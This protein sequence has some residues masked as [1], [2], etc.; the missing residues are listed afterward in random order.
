[1][2]ISKAQIKKL[3]DPK[4]WKRGINYYEQGNVLSLLEDKET[5]IAKVAGTRNYKVRL[6]FKNSQLK[7]LCNCPMGDMGVFC[8]HCVAVGL[9]YM[10]G[11]NSDKNVS[12]TNKIKTS[13]PAITL[14]NVREYLSRKQT[15]EL[16]EIIT[17]QLIENDSL[18]ERLMMEVAY[19]S[20]KEP[21]VSA[22]KKT[23][24][25]VTKTRGFV[26]YHR[27]YD[28]IKK[29]DN[30]LDLVE[31]LL[32]TG[33]AKE[34]IELSEHALKHVEKA[35]GEMDDSDGYIGGILERLQILHHD[36]C[37]KNKPDPKE[38]ARRLFE[39]ELTTAWDTFYH[40]VETYTDVLGEEGLAVYR[41]LAEAE[42]AKLPPLKP[43]QISL[44]YRSNRYRLTSIME[45]LTKIS[46]DVEQLVA[47]KS[48]DLSSAYQFLQIAGIYKESGNSDKALEWAEKGVK[49][50]SDNP[51][52][53]LNEFLA[54]EYHNR[55]LHNQAMEL[56]WQ[57]FTRWPDLAFYQHLKK[58]ADRCNQWSKWRLK[59][60]EYV[61]ELINETKKQAEDKQYYG[62]STRHSNNSILI[63]IFLWENDIEAAWKEAKQGG[64]HDYLWLRLAEL[65]EKNYPADAIGVYKEQIGPLVGQTKNEA[66]R[67]AIGLIKKIQ[68]LTGKLGRDKQF[69]EYISYIRTEYK[70]KRNLIAMLDRLK[71]K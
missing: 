2:K 5:V 48:K 1:M 65:R 23:I 63:E 27:V 57:D 26:E 17:D 59:A 58:H 22:L 40:A 3:T 70:R 42:W 30:V 45:S 20:Q 14:E 19:F 49:T 47:V 50:F 29:I 18:R 68:K 66:Y 8:K 56:I 7:G 37:A 10:D 36:A 71:I 28:F 60:L 69:K 53:R 31:K 6:S 33:F 13:E 11:V 41:K 25:K 44:S 61:R 21:D 4:S 54:N 16:V 55:N 39:W 9:A 38:L 15:D 64:C 46:G 12:S 51:D 24:T 35:M 52:S 62:F 43:G 67:E 34:V 32:D